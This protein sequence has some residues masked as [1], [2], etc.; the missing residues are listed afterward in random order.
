MDRRSFFGDCSARRADGRSPDTCRNA[1]PD[2]AAA[3]RSLQS[4]RSGRAP[5]STSRAA[6]RGTAVGKMGSRW[7]SEQAAADAIVAISAFTGA[8]DDHT[9]LMAPTSTSRASVPARKAPYERATS[10]RC[11]LSNTVFGSACRPRRHQLSQ[12]SDRARESGAGKPQFRRCHRR[13]RLRGYG[14]SKQSGTDITRVLSGLRAG[15]Q[16]PPKTASSFMSRR[17]PSCGR[18]CSREGQAIALTNSERAPCCRRADRKES[19]HAG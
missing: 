16:R 15:G 2:L 14:L 11:P 4:C 9:L 12:R 7:W 5:V 19:G 18:R 17:T 13:Q 10:S 8:N 3:Q 6:D 1:S